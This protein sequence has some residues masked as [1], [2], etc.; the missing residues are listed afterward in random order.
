M[1]QNT[2]LIT[3]APRM[4]L[5]VGPLS[6]PEAVIHWSEVRPDVRSRLYDST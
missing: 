3:M 4:S 1:G 2:S 5:Y 6:L